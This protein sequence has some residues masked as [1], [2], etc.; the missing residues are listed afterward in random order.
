MCKCNVAIYGYVL[1]I[2]VGAGFKPVQPKSCRK[3]EE[4]MISVGAGSKPALHP[5]KIY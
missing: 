4:I 1:M 3:R 5:Q 2:S